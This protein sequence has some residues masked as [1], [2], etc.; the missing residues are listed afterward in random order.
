MYTAQ[1]RAR[2]CALPGLQDEEPNAGGGVAR[3]E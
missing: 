1:Y 3:V 2:P